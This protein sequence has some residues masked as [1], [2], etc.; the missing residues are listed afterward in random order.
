MDPRPPAFWIHQTGLQDP[1]VP[2]HFN[3]YKSLNETITAC[4]AM[5]LISLFLLIKYLQR[6]TQNSFCLPFLKQNSTTDFS[7]SDFQFLVF[8]KQHMCAFVYLRALTWF[9]T[10]F[11]LIFIIWWLLKTSLEFY[12]PT[13][14]TLWNIDIIFPLKCLCFT[15]PCAIAIIAVFLSFVLRATLYKTS[16]NFHTTKVDSL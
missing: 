1:P 4:L 9:I 16:N 12:I 8:N 10:Y 3:V 7:Q 14:S 6:L 2:S 11:R 5:S 13:V 15:L